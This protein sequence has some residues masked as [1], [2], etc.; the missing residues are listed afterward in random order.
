MAR[1]HQGYARGVARTRT[2]PRTRSEYIN[3]HASATPLNDKTETMAIKQVFGDYAG[4]VPMSG[5]KAMHGHALGASGAFEIAISCL[6]MQNDYL[7]PT[8]NLCN[9]DPGCD[10]DYI[11]GDRAAPKGKHNILKLL[12]IR[13]Y[14]RLPGPQARLAF[15]QDVRSFSC[16]YQLDAMFTAFLM[17]NL[18]CAQ[19]ALRLKCR[20]CLS[21][22]L[23]NNYP[24]VSPLGDS[25]GLFAHYIRVA[26]LLMVQ[27]IGKHRDS[28][29]SQEA[30]RRDNSGE[31]DS[32]RRAVQTDP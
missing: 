18:T 31:S 6:A 25:Q 15:L 10:L 28:S 3:A 22:L 24:F 12:R 19:R 5:T 13:G 26:M 2:W 4:K 1:R 20:R 21:T 17:E 9:P 8:I 23:T 27:R 16:S 32:A 14:Q 7:P 29:S 11:S 30:Y